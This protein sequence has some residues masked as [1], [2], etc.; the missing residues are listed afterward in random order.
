MSK[1]FN[2][3]ISWSGDRSKIIA[4]ALKDWL[5]RVLQSARPWLSTR[6]IE[7][8][9]RSLSEMNKALGGMGLGIS[10]LTPENLGAPWI[11]YEAGA[12]SKTFDDD[13]SRLWTYLLSGLKPQD[14]EP[15]LSQFQHTRAEEKETLT[16][17]QSINTSINTVEDRLPD[18]VVKDA[19]NAFWPTLKKALDALPAQ[20]KP[21]KPKRSSD[22]MIAEILDLCRQFL[23]QMDAL[24]TSLRESVSLATLTGNAGRGNFS[25]LKALAEMGNVGKTYYVKL[26]SDPQLRIVRGDF[27]VA[28]KEKASILIRTIGEPDTRFDD[29]E[30]FWTE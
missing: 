5:P 28:D 22:E 4:E 14:V 19:F 27:H 7:K 26:K 1:P 12:L 16:L 18:D 29:V 13:R 8:G 17:V 6:D 21:I 11:L 25:R 15:P 10:C 20:E 9:T 30:E 2:I 24:D 23:P 3:F